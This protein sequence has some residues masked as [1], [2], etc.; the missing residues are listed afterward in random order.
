MIA[1]VLQVLMWKKYNTGMCFSLSGMSEGKRNCVHF[2]D[3]TS[4]TQMGSYMW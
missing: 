4:T 1:C 3:T 2:G